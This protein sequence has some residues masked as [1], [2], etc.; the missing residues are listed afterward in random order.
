MT[1]DDIV[2]AIRSWSLEDRK[3]LSRSLLRRGLEIEWMTPH[4]AAL[5]ASAFGHEP[6]LRRYTLATPLTAYAYAKNVEGPSDDTREIACRDRGLT[7]EYALHV[8]KG[9]HP[10]TRAASCLGSA[11]A[12]EYAHRVDKGVWYPE[13]RDAVAKAPYEAAE[14]ARLTGRD[15]PVLKASACK[16]PLAAVRYARFVSRAPCDDTRT[17]ACADSECAL[18]Y[19]MYVDC[20]H[21]EEVWEAVKGTDAE[22][23][24][25]VY[26]ELDGEEGS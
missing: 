17:A 19:A 15:D 21:T 1:L 24:Y 20:E 25:V 13:A 12:R 11:L 4:V 16:D 3:R 2:E 5:Q 26:F 10:V 8:D 9:P 18:E 22:A 6:W 14:Y 7:I 23:T